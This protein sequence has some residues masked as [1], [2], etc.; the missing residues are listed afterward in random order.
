[1]AEAYRFDGLR[2]DAVHA[3]AEAGEPHLLHELSRAAGGLAR[4][5]R[6]ADPS[7]AGE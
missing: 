3:I 7:R 4:E 2:L 5:N 6:P 1:L